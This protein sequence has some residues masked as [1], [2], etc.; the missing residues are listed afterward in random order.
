M[1]SH[2]GLNDAVFN[3]LGILKRPGEGLS[4]APAFFVDKNRLLC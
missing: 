1:H 2:P 3:I 4:C